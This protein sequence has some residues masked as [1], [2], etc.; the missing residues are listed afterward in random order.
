MQLDVDNEPTLSL[1]CVIKVVH[2]YESV[3]HPH[4]HYMTDKTLTSTHKRQ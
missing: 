4:K 1:Q 3:L 2:I